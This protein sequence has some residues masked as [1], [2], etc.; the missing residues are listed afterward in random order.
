M[1][2]TKSSKNRLLLG[3][4]NKSL[5]TRVLSSINLDNSILILD[6]QYYSSF[7][8]N[9]LKYSS[10]FGQKWASL[11][12]GQNDSL[13]LQAVDIIFEP[14]VKLKRLVKI[15]Y[16]VLLCRQNSLL[17]SL[18]KE[19][20]KLLN[21]IA[22]Y[23]LIVFNSISEVYSLAVRDKQRY[24]ILTDNLDFWAICN[25]KSDIHHCIIA[26]NN[27]IKLYTDKFGLEYLSSI[28]GTNKLVNKLRLSKIKYVNLQ[29]LYLLLLYVK[30]KKVKS[31]QNLDL[32]DK[33][34]FGSTGM[35][36]KLLT[37]AHR[38]I[39]YYFLTKED[40]PEIF[41]FSSATHFVLNLSR[42]LKI[43]QF[44]LTLMSGFANY[45]AANA[46][47]NIDISLIP[48]GKTYYK[49]VEKSK[50]Y[51][52]QDLPRKTKSP[53]RI[54]PTT[55]PELDISNMDTSMAVDS[56]LRSLSW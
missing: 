21:T 41:L 10:S 17:S 19:I 2:I 32:S 27:N 55:L 5:N 9:K 33:S 25:K 30:F 24:L 11:A 44:D 34:Y 6:I 50:L 36:L 22:R 18:E 39:S 28:I 54:L 56:I 8:A 40:L 35:A 20:I 45:Y 42:L 53:K 31:N 12:S 29:Y 7:I 46:I 3:E 4:R 1:I 26:K 13:S 15:E 38:E 14:I 37:D 43:N 51:S 49:I 52:F 48:L 16:I 47:K 23:K